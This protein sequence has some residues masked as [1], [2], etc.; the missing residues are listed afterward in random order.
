MIVAITS[1]Q[2]K[3]LIEALGIAAEIAEIESA[4]GV[5]FSSDEG[6]RFEHRARLNSI[7][8]RAVA[9]RRHD[10]L[11]ALFEKARVCWGPYR[12]LAQGL[13]QDPA[14]SDSNPLLARV[15]H[16]SG[17]SYLTPGAAAGFSAVKRDTPVRAPRLGEHTD[18]VLA[19]L[20]GMSSGEIGALHDRGIVAGAGYRK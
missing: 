18:E 4:T 2:W 10:E 3:A 13:A 9:E 20:L 19:D 6:R 5:S 17:E 12:T 14:M 7:V 16:P 15:A 11:V 8:E 1:Q